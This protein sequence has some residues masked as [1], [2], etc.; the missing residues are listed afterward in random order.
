M[1]HDDDLRSPSPASQQGPPAP[2]CIALTDL[3]ADWRL[4]LCASNKA[5]R[6]VDV[7][8]QAGRKFAEYLGPDTSIADVTHRDIR[9][10]LVHLAETPHQRTGR[11]VTDSYVAGNYRRLQQLFRWLEEEEEITASPFH[12]LRPPAVPEKPV[13]VLTEAEIRSLLVTR[14]RRAQALL[15]VMLDTGVRVAELVSMT[16]KDPSLVYGKGRRL[17]T[18]YWGDRTEL[19]VRR[20]LR[21]R[22][23]RHAALWVGKA[24][25]L[26]TDGV[27]QIIERL[28][29]D[30][31]IT[32]LHPH[33]FRHTFAHYWRASGGSEGDL[34]RLG[35][36][37][38]RQMLDR[39]GASSADDRAREAHKRLSL[40]DRF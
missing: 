39:Y 17:R 28:G 1:P 36:W 14:D 38:S 40:G 27:R 37:R 2:G 25:P 6:T 11:R 23:D 19:A 29:Q 7:Y 16:R 26:T 15:R 13:P 18:V 10:Y 3:L 31:G 22:T 5:P 33:I 8:L 12:R 4:A 35:G 34:M 9:R 32:G 21:T 20:Y 30:A 24:G